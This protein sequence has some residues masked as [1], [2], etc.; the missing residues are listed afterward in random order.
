MTRDGARDTLLSKRLKPLLNQHLNIWKPV[1]KEENWNIGCSCKRGHITAKVVVYSIVRCF[2]T[3]PKIR[4]CCCFISRSSFNSQQGCVQS[5]SSVR[6]Y[7]GDLWRAALWS[8]LFALCS[9]LDWSGNLRPEAE[10][11]NAKC[12]FMDTWVESTF[13]QIPSTSQSVK[14]AFR[15]SD[16]RLGRS[17]SSWVQ[18]Q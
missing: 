11:W 15:N 6:A 1:V 10:L 3:G 18:S 16:Q 13:S 12:F 4:I 9:F 5:S 7:F 8:A 2:Y 14:T 17:E